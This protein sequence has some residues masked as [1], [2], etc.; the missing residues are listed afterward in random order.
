MYPFYKPIQ[1]TYI[2]IKDSQ[3]LAEKLG[4]VGIG[5]T[6]V[7]QWIINNNLGIKMDGVKGQWLVNVALF[8]TFMRGQ[9]K[10]KPLNNRL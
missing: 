10:E 1:P 6:K 3:V 4:G 8:E 5:R 9:I 2:S 7:T